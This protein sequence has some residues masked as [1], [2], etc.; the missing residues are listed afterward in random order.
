MTRF[1]GRV[2][3]AKR[4]FGSYRLDAWE[5]P[6]MRGMQRGLASRSPLAKIART[7]RAHLVI[8]TNDSFSDCRWEDLQTC[9]GCIG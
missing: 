8:R 1:I 7:L 3:A 6:I 4:C 9:K 5:L 2:A